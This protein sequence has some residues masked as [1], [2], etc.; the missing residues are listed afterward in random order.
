MSR[1]LILSIKSENGKRIKVETTLNIIWK[2]EILILSLF[3]KEKSSPK[4]INS[5]RIK[6]MI[7]PMRLK[8]RWITETCFAVLE[9]PADEII[10]GITA[11]IF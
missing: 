9:A 10:T 8:R 6:N 2:R 11:P 1:S 5:I 3:A 7:V 4:G